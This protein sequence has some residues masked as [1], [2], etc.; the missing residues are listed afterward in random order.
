MG[1]ADAQLGIAFRRLVRRSRTLILSVGVEPPSFTVTAFDES[2]ERC[3][4]TGA[5]LAALVEALAG[6]PPTRREEPIDEKTVR[7]QRFAHTLA[8][9]AARHERRAP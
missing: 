1:E 6:P 4:A 9:Y 3:T 5:D 2:G 7:R 8:R